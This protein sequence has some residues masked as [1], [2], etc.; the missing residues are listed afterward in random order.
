[1]V[2]ISLILDDIFFSIKREVRQVCQIHVHLVRFSL[3]PKAPPE[4]SAGNR[5]MIIRKFIFM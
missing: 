3:C 1:M 2:I 5:Q 4:V